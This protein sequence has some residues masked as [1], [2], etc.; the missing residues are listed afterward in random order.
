MEL[1]GTCEIQYANNLLSSKAVLR[2]DRDRDN[3]YV[4]LLRIS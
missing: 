3:P 4:D 2:T 1:L